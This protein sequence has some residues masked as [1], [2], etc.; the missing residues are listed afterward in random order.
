MLTET[1]RGL[2][3]GKFPLSPLS[4]VC[5]SFTANKRQLTLRCGEIVSMSKSGGDN[6]VARCRQQRISIHTVGEQ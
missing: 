6:G 1:L 5:F 4:V 3:K 2:R